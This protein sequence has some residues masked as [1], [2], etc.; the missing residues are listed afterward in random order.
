MSS[1]RTILFVA[2]FFFT[3]VFPTHLHVMISL[4]DKLLKYMTENITLCGESEFKK[5]FLDFVWV[6]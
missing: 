2:F 4:N 5:K 3:F 1:Y 6:D